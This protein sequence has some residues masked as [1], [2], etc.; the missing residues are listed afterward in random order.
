MIRPI[1]IAAESWVTRTP[2][3]PCRAVRDRKGDAGGFRPSPMRRA[4]K[5]PCP[6]RSAPP[7]PPG[8]LRRHVAGRRPAAR[9][10]PASPCWNDS[11]LRGPYFA[12]ISSKSKLSI[13]EGGR[14]VGIAAHPPRPAARSRPGRARPAR[15]ASRT[16]APPLRRRADQARPWS[17]GY[18]GHGGEIAETTACRIPAH[19]QAG[20]GRIRTRK[21]IDRAIIILRQLRAQ[22]Q[23][24]RRARGG[25][26]SVRRGAGGGGPGQLHRARAVLGQFARDQRDLDRVVML[27]PRIEAAAGWHGIDCNILRSR[28][29]WRGRRQCAPVRAAWEAIHRSSRPSAK[30]A[31]AQAVSTGAALMRLDLVAAGHVDPGQGVAAETGF[32]NW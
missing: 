9:H 18:R 27:Q 7:S 15:R 30:R 4:G 3:S 28:C 6:L 26:G 12:A 25:C 22:Q 13:G 10:C 1:S 24:G 11:A 8:Q 21:G 16:A 32:G 20:G 31:T 17:R 5:G 14:P 23:P 19:G 29:R 2:P